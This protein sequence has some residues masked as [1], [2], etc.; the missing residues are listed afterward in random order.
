MAHL[1][2]V[3]TLF[4]ARILVA[5]LGAEGILWELRGASEVYPVGQT[6]VWVDEE[7]LADARNLLLSDE[8]EAVFD[9]GPENEPVEVDED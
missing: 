9:D 2:S 4:E 1:A 8:V 7:S 5:R 6:H 3:D